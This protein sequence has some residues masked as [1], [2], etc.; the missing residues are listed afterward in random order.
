MILR[1]L[2]KEEDALLEFNKAIEIR[3]T[4]SDAYFERAELLTD[5]NKKEEALVDYNKTIELDPKKA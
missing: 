2:K 3:P 1:A 5:M 4:S